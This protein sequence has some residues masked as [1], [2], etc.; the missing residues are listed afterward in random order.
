MVLSN[1]QMD[2]II[3]SAK[4]EFGEELPDE[5]IET[6]SG[7]RKLSE[8][9]ETQLAFETTFYSKQAGNRSLSACL[10]FNKAVTSYMKYIESL[11][12]GSNN[13]LFRYGD[14]A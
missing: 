2:S 1:E 5:V 4:K 12:E 7:G 14:W 3:E 10:K 13:V 11:P 8:T 6:I 9:E